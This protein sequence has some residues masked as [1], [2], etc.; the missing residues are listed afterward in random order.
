M[1]KI[2]ELTT[3][4]ASIDKEEA[5][6]ESLKEKASADLSL[7]AS[8]SISIKD[9][10]I[11]ILDARLSFDLADGQLKKIEPLQEKVGAELFAEIRECAARWNALVLQKR[12]TIEENLILGT[13]PEFEHNERAARRWWGSEGRLEQM[14]IFAKFRD[15][16]FDESSLLI[17]PRWSVSQMATHF[18]SW[19]E[20]HSGA[21]GIKSTDIESL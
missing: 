17:S 13:L 2:T 5:K 15:A 9:A 3:Q 16:Y 18:C 14:P 12:R 4:L 11:K 6:L 20:R 21:L 7:A 10:R 8:P 1:K 19:I